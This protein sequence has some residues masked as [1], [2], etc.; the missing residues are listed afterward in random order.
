M[1][2]SVY[3]ITIFFV[4]LLYATISVIIYNCSISDF[5]NVVIG[6]KLDIELL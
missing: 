3:H 5:S 1:I 6:K 4:N 2:R